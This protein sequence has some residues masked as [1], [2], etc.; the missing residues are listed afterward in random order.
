MGGDFN[1]LRS[2]DKNNNSN[3]KD[4]WPSFFNA[5][6]GWLKFKGNPNVRKKIHMDKHERKSNIRKIG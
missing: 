2:P 3:Y 4:R 5:V 1:I 6:I